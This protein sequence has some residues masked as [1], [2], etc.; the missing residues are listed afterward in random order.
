MFDFHK[1][2]STGLDEVNG[3]S[4]DTPIY[5]GSFVVQLLGL[6]GDEDILTL[7]DTYTTPSGTV[8]LFTAL[9]IA[10]IYVHIKLNFLGYENIERLGKQVPF[11]KIALCLLSESAYALTDD[12]K[13]VDT[14]HRVV[15]LYLAHKDLNEDIRELCRVLKR[16]W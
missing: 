12:K 15:K 6:K 8:K 4:F 7:V 9:E 1:V 16:S 13:T 5:S 14:M 3:A 11:E 2:L 10:H